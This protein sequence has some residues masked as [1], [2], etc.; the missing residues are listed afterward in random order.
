ML[1]KLSPYQRIKLVN[2]IKQAND[3]SVTIAYDMLEEFDFDNIEQSAKAIGINSED[4][5]RIICEKYE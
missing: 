3:T 1:S 4:V 2:I 5:E